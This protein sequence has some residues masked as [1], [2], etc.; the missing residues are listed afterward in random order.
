MI[1]IRQIR[2]NT[3]KELSILKNFSALALVQVTN[4]LVPLITFP[5]L[6]R[7]VGLEKF[8][9]ISYGLTILTYLLT[10][11]D[12]GFNLSATR[13]VAIHRDDK[14]ELSKL[15][16][17]VMTTK[18]FLLC[19]CTLV[20]I[21]LCLL[22]PRFQ[23]ESFIYMLGLLYILGSVL[24]PVWLFQGLE[25]MKYITYANVVAKVV[26]LAL[27]FILIRSQQDY[28]FVLGLYGVANI[29]SGGYSIWL[30]IKRYNLRFRLT[31]LRIVWEQLRDSWYFFSA[32]LSVMIANN[33]SVLLLGFF[34]SNKDIGYYSI[35]EKVIFVVWTVLGLFSQTIYPSVCRLI[36]DHQRLRRFVR[37]VCWPF[38]GL[39]G[40]GCLIVYIMADFIVELIVGHSEPQTAYILRIMSVVPFIVSLN[41]PAYQILLAYSY[42]KEPAAIFNISAVANLAL[43]STLIYVWG[44]VG[45]AVC[46]VIVQI[47]V[48][49][50]LH[51]VVA[52]KHKN[53]SLNQ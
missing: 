48:T 12:Y 46:M 26:Q 5:Y 19:L 2:A 14:T 22:V 10:F 7:I 51:A 44:V 50:S 33:T 25:K 38:A 39:V 24:M 8:G 17:A 20:M 34:V 21:G 49:L 37:N 11:A 40:I 27:L 1:T 4:F 18:L 31:P 53:L 47:A 29:A 13:L 6:V 30:A 16:S 9:V 43:C 15:F 23:Q 32:N 45:A 52:L 42:K 36:D 35:A 3:G 41:I 28:I